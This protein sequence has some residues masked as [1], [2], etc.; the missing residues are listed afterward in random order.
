MKLVN[1]NVQGISSRKKQYVLWQTLLSNKWDVLCAVEHKQHRQVSG[2]FIYK[3]FHVFFSGHPSTQSGVMMIVNGHFQPSVVFR[4]LHGHFLVVKITFEG[5]LFWLVGVYAP[6]SVRAR[7]SLWQDLQRCLQLGKPGFL[8][9]DFNTCFSA[10]QS[11]SSHVIM[12]S[13]ERR[14]WD[15]FASLVL[16]QD[17]WS[18]LHQRDSGFTFH[19]RQFLGPWSRLYVMHE[20]SFLPDILQVTMEMQH[21]LSDH[22]PL[23]LDLLHQPVHVHKSLLERLPSRFNHSFLDHEV[24]DGYMLQLIDNFQ[25]CFLQQGMSA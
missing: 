4:D 22:F 17:N 5:K 25:M 13:P 2:G 20:D 10:D 12:D 14:V 19:S 8:M 15:S 24:F 21:V 16:K 6:H 23:V 7:C 1:W 11:T 3:G 18:W 9:G